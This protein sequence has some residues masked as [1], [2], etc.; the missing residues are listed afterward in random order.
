MMGG[1]Q[2]GKINQ[3]SFSNNTVNAD[4]ERALDIK[5]D[6]TNVIITNND[7]KSDGVEVIYLSAL[8]ISNI[9]ISSNNIYQLSSTPESNTQAGI[10]S[11]GVGGSGF[12]VLT[13][14]FVGPE[15]ST[16][17]FGIAFRNTSNDGKIRANFQIKGNKFW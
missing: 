8:N 16:P 1:V 10:Y 9:E 13:N 17:A 15:S 7:L 6:V 5:N 2:I 12:K 4:T 11:E 14:N 3:L